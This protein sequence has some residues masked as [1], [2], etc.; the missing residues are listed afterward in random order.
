[1]SLEDGFNAFCKEAR[2]KTGEITPKI[3]I[4]EGGVIKMNLEQQ[5][6]L[7]GVNF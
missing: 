2:I 6:P 7:A 4:V 3:K 1:M 5:D